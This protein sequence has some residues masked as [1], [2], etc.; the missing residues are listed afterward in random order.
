VLCGAADSHGGGGGISPGQCGTGKGGGGGFDG[1]VP[2]AEEASWRL[3][4]TPARSYGLGKKREGLGAGKI[5]QTSEG[6][7]AHRVRVAV[8]AL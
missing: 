5:R 1:G 4:K 3:R 6:S 7:G 8:A 2:I